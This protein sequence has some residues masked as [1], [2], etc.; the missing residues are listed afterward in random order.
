MSQDYDLVDGNL[1]FY[2]NKPYLGESPEIQSGP[3][4][5]RFNSER[6]TVTAMDCYEAFHKEEQ[7]EKSAKRRTNGNKKIN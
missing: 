1:K 2:K 5:K 3:L 7:N 4:K 6:F